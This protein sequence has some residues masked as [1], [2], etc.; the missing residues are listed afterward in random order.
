MKNPEKEKEIKDMKFKVYGTWSGSGYSRVK[1]I[2]LRRYVGVAGV[3][4]HRRS[5]G[6]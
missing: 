3:H 1:G 2:I 6:R 4:R 5:T